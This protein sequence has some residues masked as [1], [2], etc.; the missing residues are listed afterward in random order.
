[1]RDTQFELNQA[2]PPRKQNWLSAV[3]ASALAATVLVIPLCFAGNPSGHDLQAHIAAW[4]EIRGQWH[5]GIWFPR[6]AEWANL[7]FGEPRFIFY[8]PASNLLGAA[9][10]TFLPWKMVPGALIWLTLLAA[11]LSMYALAREWLSHNQALL[12]AILFTLN[13]YT[14]VII[15]YRSAFAEL[16]A[17]AFFP[18]LVCGVVEIVR[19]NWWRLP[20]AAL[21]F[22]M[23]WLSNAPAAVIATY[24]FALLLAGG[25]VIRRSAYPL[26][27]GVGAMLAGLGLAA[28]YVLPAAWE[29]RWINVASIADDESNPTRNFLFTRSNTADFIQFNWKVSAVA[30]AMIIVTAVAISLSARERRGRTELWWMLV[31]L[32]TV[33]TFLMLPPSSFV[34]NH[35]PKLRFL[36]F[37]WRWLGALGLS[38]AF[39]VAASAG[40]KRRGLWLATVIALIF[41]GGISVAA[42]T[43]WNSEDVAEVVN[44]FNSGAGYE[45]IEF[46]PVGADPSELDADSPRIQKIDEDG[47]I[48]ELGDDV[49]V[50]IHRWSVE[51]R[52]FSITTKQEVTLAV[53]LLNYPAWEVL[54][55]AKP[56]S[57]T[58]FEDNG[59]MLITVPEGAHG[60]EMRFRRTRDRTVGGIISIFSVL[61]L[62]VFGALTWWRSR[63]IR[64]RPAVQP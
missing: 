2:D 3:Y 4:M 34:W 30:A 11:G 52:S 44:D 32:A 54:I 23:I 51:Q 62:I 15:Y 27:A 29:Q 50:Q 35:L 8:P 46:D 47:D 18:L 42:S 26:I 22:G 24:S 57:V 56:A 41:A 38:F 7:G 55:D 17:T 43:D 49:K 45:G 64:I 36:Q 63:K 13:P 53:K 10:G 14:L 31:I 12:A 37:P 20:L 33:A 61:L 60:L 40:A 9:L 58:S 39:F 21:A 28:F 25:C 59:Q 16:V 1:M 6:W 19:G 48:A 5:E